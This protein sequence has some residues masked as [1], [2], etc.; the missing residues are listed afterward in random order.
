M[1]GRSYAEM[2]SRPSALRKPLLYT[3][4]ARPASS[5]RRRLPPPP[6]NRGSTSTVADSP[7][8]LLSYYLS[9]A[10]YNTRVEENGEDGVASATANTG[11]SAMNEQKDS[12]REGRGAVGDDRRPPPSYCLDC[13]A[14]PASQPLKDTTGTLSNPS[15]PSPRHHL[16]SA[17]MPPTSA[18]THKATAS[19]DGENYSDFGESRTLAALRN[20]SPP[21]PAATS[22]QS[23]AHASLPSSPAS[24]MPHLT[25][26]TEEQHRVFEAQVLQ[27][28]EALLQAQRSESLAELEAHRVMAAEAQATL[29]AV[30]AALSKQIGDAQLNRSSNVEGPEACVSSL[31]DDCATHDRPWSAPKAVSPLPFAPS[32]DELALNMSRVAAAAATPA[33]MKLLDA[34]MDIREG[35]RVPAALQRVMEELYIELAHTLVP[36]VIDFVKQQR[37]LLRVQRPTAAM[38]PLA[39]G[40]HGPHSDAVRLADESVRAK[41]EV[42]ALQ[43][44]VRA[45]RRTLRSQEIDLASNNASSASGLALSTPH[46]TA[47]NAQMHPLQEELVCAL[48]DRLFSEYHAMLTRSLQEALLLRCSLAEEKRQHFLTRL[49]LLKPSHPLAPHRSGA[50]TSTKAAAG[51]HAGPLSAVARS[52]I[53]LGGSDGTASSPKLRSGSSSSP[54]LHGSSATR[55]PTSS[56]PDT[57]GSPRSQ[58]P[59]PTSQS[60]GSLLSAGHRAAPHRWTPLRSPLQLASGSGVMDEPDGGGDFGRHPPSVHSPAP[61]YAPLPPPPLPS[62]SLDRAVPRTAVSLE[63]A[64]RVAEEV[65]CTAAPIAGLHREPAHPYDSRG[66][67]GGAGAWRH[68]RGG[69][70]ASAPPLE[71]SE[72]A[73]LSPRRG[74]RPGQ[75]PRAREQSLV[76]NKLPR[77]ANNDVRRAAPSLVSEY[78]TSVSPRRE[79][80]GLSFAGALGRHGGSGGTGAGRISSPTRSVSR[81]DLAASAAG[82]APAPPT[83]AYE[84]RVWNK[85]LEL[86]SRYSIA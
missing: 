24:F 58:A 65:L 81:D 32:M 72:G 62:A 73:L 30:E 5:P 38:E 22:S 86:L 59:I 84:R 53:D 52:R 33:T 76:F 3:P 44:E 12:V 43:E 66:S 60:A 50:A 41:A 48:Q 77:H 51:G 67:G 35:E 75:S 31:R 42:T 15:P 39:P 21:A 7:R 14:S 6:N 79:H 25:L 54:V 11:D 47:P 56:A 18:I 36:P 13:L 16:A 46:I 55:S 4:A 34:I 17:L 85:T 61:G 40:V 68:T 23:A 26:Y 69:G 2:M 9:K 78:S 63:N 29:Q 8:R 71:S 20:S 64:M 82:A 1:P 74:E 57:D 49:R 45:L 10:A 19:R 28:V 80:S 83:D 27:Q 37:Q 70:D